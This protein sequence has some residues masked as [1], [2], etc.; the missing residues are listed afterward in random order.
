MEDG[1]LVDGGLVD[2]GLSPTG[3]R[4]EFKNV[5]ADAVT[6]SAVIKGPDYLKQLNI[7]L[8]SPGGTVL[9][10]PAGG[11]YR[12]QA[13]AL[14]G[15][16]QVVP[17]AAGGSVGELTVVP[18][19]MGL[20]ELSL[21]EST[22]TV[23]PQTPK[24]VEP[25]EAFDI[26]LQ[27][28]DPA[29]MLSE[30]TSATLYTGTAP[31]N[32]LAGQPIHGTLRSIDGGYRLDARLV[33]PEGLGTL[34]Y[35]VGIYNPLFA[36]ES[37]P[38][39]PH[40]ISPALSRGQSLHTIKVAYHGLLLQILNIPIDADILTAVVDGPSLTQPFVATAQVQGNEASMEIPLD[41][42]GPFRVR[43]IASLLSGPQQYVIAGGTLGGISIT[44]DETTT[45]LI[46]LEVASLVVEQPTPARVGIGEIIPLKVKVVDPAAF[47]EEVAQP[48]NTA[49]E[50][51][52]DTAPFLNRGGQT[53]MTPLILNPSEGIIF[54]RIDVQAPNNPGVL[55]YQAGVSNPLFTT[56][57]GTPYLMLPNTARGQSLLTVDIT[58]TPTTG[59]HLSITEMPEGVDRVYI[60][61]DL[62]GNITHKFE[63][64]PTGTTLIRDLRVPAGGPYRIRV[65]VAGRPFKEIVTYG[66]RADTVMVVEGART[67]V[68]VP[69]SEF[70]VIRD[71]ATPLT[72]QPGSLITLK[73]L[74][75]D[76]GGF[77]KDAMS[78]VVYLGTEPYSQSDRERHPGT[79]T[80]LTE[81]TYSFET[82]FTAPP[83]KGM[84][85]YQLYS[86]NY[87]LTNS[88]LK[89]TLPNPISGLTLLSLEIA[90]GSSGIDLSL[91]NIPT[92][93][94]HLLL[95]LD[96]ET[97]NLTGQEN[98]P[99][100]ILNRGTS[101]TLPLGAPPG[102]AHCVRAMAG[103]RSW[104]TT[105]LILASGRVCGVSVEENSRT[106][107]G[108]ALT[109]LTA[110]LN[111][112][113]PA[114]I[115]A[116]T[117]FDLALDIIDP[118]QLIGTQWGYF[119][120][121]IYP[122]LEQIGAALYG[123][124][125]PHDDY[126]TFQK[127]GLYAP[128]IPTTLYFMFQT[129][130]WAHALQERAA[131]P[132]SLL[133]DPPLQITITPPLQGL[134][135]IPTGIPLGAT[136]FYINVVKDTGEA[137][138]AWAYDATAEGEPVIIGT[139][140]GGPYELRF[141]VAFGAGYG[142][143]Y[144]YVGGRVAGLNIP[145][146]QFV[147]VPVSLSKPQV[148][149]NETPGS[150]TAGEP[151]ELSLTVDDPSGMLKSSSSWFRLN[152]L[153]LYPTKTELSPTRF[154]FMTQT[155]APSQ[156]GNYPYTFNWSDY[157]RN[158]LRFTWFPL[159][160]VPREFIGEPALLLRVNAN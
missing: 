102:P 151:F 32:D 44:A 45:A 25:K 145:A 66:G 67:E 34:F 155:Y 97:P 130:F 125:V 143:G 109:N 49:G 61:I 15:S 108:L 65:H 63:Y 64:V 23:D 29:G 77:L 35:Q 51:H 136:T 48:G 10:L 27:L 11:P 82:T 123:T 56:A 138:L 118:S 153:A 40:L 19:E 114:T 68:T 33:A 73:L 7:G 37:Y 59:V 120:Y 91:S 54:E 43:V 100:F 38:L 50:F 22:V 74:I 157:N 92:Q 1:G 87:S 30:F 70:S 142:N 53:T 5:P 110:R 150:T 137:I 104:G 119:Q 154:K 149:L 13:L 141:S 39:H 140:S 134:K 106:Q 42:G 160:Q 52:H 79:L 129:Y 84:L 132:S 4:I 117:S 81:S 133:G 122:N 98:V 139:P 16:S 103:A 158:S 152:G 3:L 9:E 8:P 89:L 96:D 58:E 124:L 55:H 41:P 21:T 115:P 76:P 28:S 95:W 72:I 17:I 147:E 116:G 18:G 69:V 80:A 126:F 112:G 31:F 144:V 105:G 62:N 113:V 88:T 60:T 90:G 12:I 159:F 78:P 85:Y 156:P 24:Q 128:P 111:S 148:H 14:S 121:S 71:P 36:D 47:L 101:L 26:I 2:G 20:V 6:A 93:A 146:G 107:A 131:V 127:E 57:H 86:T 83:L 75:T 94:D 46:P 135:V 99:S